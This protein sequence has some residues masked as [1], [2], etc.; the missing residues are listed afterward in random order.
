M[1]QSPRMT[2]SVPSSGCLGSI[3]STDNG[4][5]FVVFKSSSIINPSLMRAPIS[6]FRR[7][8]STSRGT[9]RLS[10]KTTMEPTSQVQIDYEKAYDNGVVYF[11]SEEEPEVG[12]LSQWYD[13]TWEHEGIVYKTAEM[14]MMIQKAKLFG[15]EV[16]PVQNGLHI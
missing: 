10:H 9:Y 5:V 6:V 13:S 8:L 16:G 4:S 14:W 15:D 1:T 12:Y 2:L 11:W 7:A 3:K